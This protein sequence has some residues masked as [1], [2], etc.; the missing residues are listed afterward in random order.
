MPST[1]FLTLAPSPG[2]IAELRTAYEAAFP[3]RRF[4]ELDPT[5]E[6]VVGGL[7][8]LG[9]VSMTRH[10][11]GGWTCSDGA[12]ST[13]ITDA[14]HTVVKAL[15]QVLAAY[16]SAEI[17]V[18]DADDIPLLRRRLLAHE[19]HA[20]GTD[21]LQGLTTPVVLSEMLGSA[22][23]NALCGGLGLPVPGM[24]PPRP[25]L[26]QVRA[27]SFSVALIHLRHLHVSDRINRAAYAAAVTKLREAA[28]ARAKQE[29]LPEAQAF[30]IPLPATP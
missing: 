18:A 17:V 26:H 14:E 29:L 28:I 8:A 9:W 24:T 1:T 22:D 10:G 23:L 20:A 3:P 30:D 2:S 15:A 21:L 11:N 19:C 13:E 25:A 16:P 12:A 7:A 5:A 6:R 4:G 27:A